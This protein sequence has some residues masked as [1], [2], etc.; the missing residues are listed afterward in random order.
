M[1]LLMMCR[2]IDLERLKKNASSFDVLTQI[3]PPMT[4]KQ[5]IDKLYDEKED[6]ATSN[7]ILEIKH[8][9]YVRGQLEK[10][11]I[12]AATRGLLHRTVNDY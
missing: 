4:M 2:D 11:V 9:H 8:G 1:N 5:K 12:G 10:S 6:P 3:M 7:Y